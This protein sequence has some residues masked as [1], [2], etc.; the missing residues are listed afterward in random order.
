MPQV[1]IP[2]IELVPHRP[3]MLL[4]KNLIRCRPEG[5]DAETV[6]DETVGQFIGQQNRVEPEILIEILAQTSA[7][8]QG[9]RAKD[10]DE[11]PKK[12]M[13]AGMDHLNFTPAAEHISFN[14]PLLSG[15][16]K[17]LEL[18]EVT[19]FTGYVRSEAEPLLEGNLKVWESHELPT[20]D[21]QESPRPECDSLFCS[22]GQ[23]SIY[24]TLCANTFPL[25][26][27]STE[28]SARAWLPSC[29]GGFSGHFPGFPILPA[30]VMVLWARVLAET[31]L[32]V[33][34]TPTEIT[35]AKFGSPAKP[36]MLLHLDL[37][38]KMADTAEP[39]GKLKISHGG[40][41][42]AQVNSKWRHRKG[43]A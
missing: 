38:L 21:T 37:E 35:R 34:L 25:S 9:W 4:V 26:Q 27:T 20:A 7:L 31:A 23:S 1:P 16:D 41:T 30:V 3:P 28:Y 11:E 22:E 8:D 10:R 17:T 18:G 5:S 42:V 39:T 12:G 15:G 6:T 13:L 19:V 29:F 14:T 43:T 32:G 33:P 2:A 40:A 36:N 24:Q